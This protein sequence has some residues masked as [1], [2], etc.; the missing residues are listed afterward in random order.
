MNLGII[1]TLFYTFLAYM[2]I[3]ILVLMLLNVNYTC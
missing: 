3:I 2:Y 1:L